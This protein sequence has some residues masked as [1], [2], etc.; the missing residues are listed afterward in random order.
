MAR[1]SIQLR[2]RNDRSVPATARLRRYSAVERG[3]RAAVVAIGGTSLGIASVAIPG[4][5]LISVWLLP[6]LSIGIG[7]YLLRVHTRVRGLQ[8]ICPQCTEDID[9]DNVGALTSEAAWIR[10][11]HCGLPLRIDDHSAALGT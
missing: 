3:M 10:C 7:A 2:T 5:H 4:V 1:Q 8:A 9:I 6:M 11:P